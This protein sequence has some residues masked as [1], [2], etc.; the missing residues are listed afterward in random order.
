MRWIGKGSIWTPRPQIDR[1]AHQRAYHSER[2]LT[3]RG[4]CLVA[5]GFAAIVCAYLL[6]ERDLLR[7]GILA[8]ALPLVALISV[9]G[10]RTTLTA[11]HRA[12]PN[13]L[14][15]GSVGAVELRIGNSGRGRSRALL[16]T[17]AP[18]AGL[19]EGV[20][21]VLPP[22]RRRATAVV[23]Y[24]LRATRRG[25]FFIGDV[26]VQ[27]GDPLGLCTH[28]QTLASSASI[29]II[30]AVA[31]LTGL[32]TL[33]GMLSAAGG[34]T[35]G[36]S[37]GGDP[38]VRVRP[39]VAGD[40]IRTIHW[41]ASARRDDV[42]VRTRQPVSHGSATVV[43]DHRAAAHR[44]QAPDSSLEQAV[45]LAA[46]IGIHILASD[47]QLLLTTHT[48]EM[49]ARGGDVS[50]DVL[51]GLAELE[52]S[53][54]T[55]LAYNVAASTG[56][57]IVVTGALTVPDVNHLVAVRPVGR[58]CMAFVLDVD[59]WVPAGR[60]ATGRAAPLPAESAAA[61][62]RS[63]GWVTTVTH[64]G[65]DLADVWRSAQGTMAYSGRHVS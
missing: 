29:L 4:R 57:I 61:L 37:V 47:Y 49:I 21:C 3:T 12:T 33:S 50:N 40:D 5:G 42:V 45:S 28:Q 24:R 17:D 22:L 58:R 65:D 44:G 43:I 25:R 35:G 27:T 41:R 32:P 48:G 62:L 55:S 30:P 34:S 23:R 8:V 46:S 60:V 53:Q 7:V 19:T 10:R 52:A 39:Y 18:T 16:V 51:I 54:T 56:M 1:D 59:G 2:G 64:R 9:F 14:H 6:D 11:E 36:S 26:T 13:R 63:G 38:D 31:P 20:R 15:P